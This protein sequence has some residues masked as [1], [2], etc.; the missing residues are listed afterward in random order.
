[1]MDAA[2]LRMLRLRCCPPLW[3][4]RQNRPEAARHLARCEH[5]RARLERGGAMRALDR[6]LGAVRLERWQ[7]TPVRAGDIRRIQPLEAREG[8]FGTQGVWFNLP[9]VLVLDDEPDDAGLVRVAQIFEEPELAGPADIRLEADSWRCAETWNVYGMS[10]Q[11]L[12]LAF[13]RVDPAFARE[14]LRRSDDACPAADRRSPLFIFR[15]CEL[16]CGSCFALPSV[17][18]ALTRMEETRG[19]ARTRAAQPG[20]AP[21]DN[22]SATAMVERHYVR[23]A[24][25]LAR[26][27]EDPAGGTTIEVVPDG[28]LS[29]TAG[30][31]R[32]A[33][34]LTD[35]GG[36]ILIPGPDGTA[37]DHLVLNARQQTEVRLPAGAGIT[38]VL[39]RTLSDGAAL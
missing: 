24:H 14:A 11:D 30:D 21:W 15:Q 31:R 9:T 34:Q 29:L 37:S 23:A 33:V 13:G 2:W 17:T 12:G 16:A 10:F 4:F 38:R 7:D 20:P 3:V 27:F 5:C 18:Q 25:H 35:S 1:M 32:C 26:C 28:R 6:R 19:A 8:C 22:A 36:V 39:I